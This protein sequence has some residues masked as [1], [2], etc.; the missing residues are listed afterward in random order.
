MINVGKHLMGFTRDF[1]AFPDKGA[2]QTP[3]NKEAK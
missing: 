2:I 3:K 1:E